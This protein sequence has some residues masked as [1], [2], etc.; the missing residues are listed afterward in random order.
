MKRKKTPMFTE[1]GLGN[2]DFASGH[3]RNKEGNATRL[4][5][6]IGYLAST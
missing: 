4:A 6:V 5:L 1:H 3:F 2:F